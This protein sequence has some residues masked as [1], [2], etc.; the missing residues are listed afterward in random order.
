MMEL[1]AERARKLIQNQEMLLLNKILLFL[2]AH[3][4][5]TKINR[6]R[7]PFKRQE[8]INN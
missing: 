2:K 6:N 1:Q 3:Q 5:K 7:K 8:K 4:E